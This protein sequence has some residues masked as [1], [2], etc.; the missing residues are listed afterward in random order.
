[1][2]LL[3]DIWNAFTSSVKGFDS[4]SQLALG[5]TM[6]MI[7]GLIPKDSLLPYL[8][9]V[10][11]LLTNANLLLLIVSG[12]TFSAISPSLDSMTHAIG[13]WTLTFDPFESFWVWCCQLPIVPWTRFENTVVMGSFALGLLAAIPVYTIG[14]QF[15]VRF[16][17][18]FF[19]LLFQNRL[20]RWLIGSPAPSLQE[21]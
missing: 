1:M 8:V 15:F 19:N 17:E 12:V 20:A 16:G 21:S 10:V 13:L 14:F 4:P 9:I 5:L 18:P 3:H 2:N 6:G 7:I 11:A